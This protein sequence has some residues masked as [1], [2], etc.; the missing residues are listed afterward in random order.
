MDE[1]RDNGYV[2]IPRAIRGRLCD[3]VVAAYGREVKPYSGVLPR[4]SQRQRYAHAFDSFGHV[5][6]P[7][8][9]RSV[10]ELG[11]PQ[12][13]AAVQIV[14]A[15]LDGLVQ[16]VAGGAPRI[17]TALFEVSSGF[18]AHQDAYYTPS[19]RES[20][21]AAWLAL[22]DISPSAG[23]FFMCP[24]SRE[25]VFWEG[26]EQVNGKKLEH[27]VLEGPLSKV[28]M[29]LKKGDVVLFD[30]MTVHG[31]EPVVDPA[32]SRFALSLHYGR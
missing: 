4:F 8:G 19:F 13:A 21:H 22:E 3:D 31:A 5:Q 18:G 30:W 24:S 12:F 11:F 23:P 29:H 9:W 25:W 10:D 17:N 27:A 20:G 14:E 7:I 26:D 32:L 15:G 16:S 6:N 2:V 28:P 1:F